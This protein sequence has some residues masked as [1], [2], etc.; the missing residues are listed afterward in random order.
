M[1]VE[2][3]HD[4]I[5]LQEGQVLVK[6]LNKFHPVIQKR[7]LVFIQVV[8]IYLIPGIYLYADIISGPFSVKSVRKL[9]GDALQIQNAVSLVFRNGSAVK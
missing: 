3:L 5:P 7:C 9:P 8:Y 1:L 2:D 4:L 6:D